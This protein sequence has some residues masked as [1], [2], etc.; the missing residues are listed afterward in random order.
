MGDEHLPLPTDDYY[1]D[2]N[3]DDIHNEQSATYSFP[4]SQRSNTFF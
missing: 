3:E 4:N 1:Y 2:A